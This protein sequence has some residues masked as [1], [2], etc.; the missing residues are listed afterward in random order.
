MISGW[1]NA[2]VLLAETACQKMIST[3]IRVLLLQNVILACVCVYVAFLSCPMLKPTF[4]FLPGS[5]DGALNVSVAIGWIA[6]IWYAFIQG[7]CGLGY[8][9]MYDSAF[10]FEI[11]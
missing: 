1:S 9:Q 5:D 10:Y 3:R 11:T 6:L 4:S 8:F 2:R 7:V